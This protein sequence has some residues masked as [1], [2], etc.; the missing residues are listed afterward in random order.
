MR[1]AGPTGAARAWCEDVARRPCPVGAR[2]PLPAR[3]GG[4]IAAI[5]L[6]VALPIQAHD[7]QLRWRTL[8]SAHIEVHHPAHL[9]VFARKVLETAEDA[10]AALVPLFGYQPPVPLQ[11]TVDD[12]VDGSNGFAG[13]FPYDHILIRAYPPAAGDDLADPGD[14]VR[15]LVFHEITHILHVGDATGLP[16]LVNTV[17]GRTHLP[18]QYL[19]RFFV[20]G[21]ATY[22][23]TR[24]VGA[25]AS[26]QRLAAA[27]GAGTRHLDADV[28][29]SGAGAGRDLA[30]VRGGR[31]DGAIFMGRLRAA[32][33][34]GTFPSVSQLIG[35]PLDWPRG[36]G[37]YLY[38]SWLLDFQARRYGHDRL[39]RFISGYGG[40]LVPYG[41]NNLTRSVYGKSAIALWREAT[42]ALDVRVRRERRLRAAGLVPPVSGDG[43]ARAHAALS[44]GAAGRCGPL[45]GPGLRLSRDGEGRGRVRMAPGGRHVVLSRSP[46]DDI[47]RIER[48]ALADG[49][50]E[51]LHRCELDCDDALIT[52]D[53]GWLLWVATRPYRRQYQFRDV[54]ARRLQ[55]G[56]GAVGPVLR[57]T[58]GLRAREISVDPAGR[59]LWAV[60]VR[61]GLTAI[62]RLPLAPALT[63]AAA[64]RAIPAVAEVLRAQRHADVL[65]TP[66]A[67]RDGRLFFTQGRGVTRELRAAPL[68][69][70]GRLSAP[71]R[72]LPW[73]PAARVG[74]AAEVTGVAARTALV[75]WLDE[76]QVIERDQGVSLGAVV[77]LGSFRD[78]AELPLSATAVAADPARD[79]RWQLRSWSPTSVV[80]AAFASGSTRAVA[81]QTEHHGLDLYRLDPAPVERRLEPQPLQWRPASAPPPF[82]PYA[83]GIAAQQQRDYRAWP[84]LYPQAWSPIAEIVAT[85]APPTAEDVTLGLSLDGRDAVGLYAWELLAQSDLALTHPRLFLSTTWT[86]WEPTLS[87]AAAWVHDDLYARRGFR[88]L[89]LRNRTASGRLG[90]AW[91]L[92]LGRDALGFDLGLRLVSR[93]ARD[94]L[95]LWRLR[96]GAPVPYGPVPVDPLQGYEGEA[97]AGVSW[98]RSERYPQSVVTERR[99]TY[100]L[101]GTWARH[102]TERDRELVRI[103]LHGD[104]A[105]PLGGHR[106]LSWRARLGW[107]PA[108]HPG[109][110]PYR[111]VGLPPLDIEALLLGG[112]GGDFGVVRGVTDP[113]RA[114]REVA[115]RALA[116]SSLGL[117]LPLPP[118][119]RGLDLLPFFL[120]RTWA[121]VFAD[122]AVILA[123]DETRL[124]EATTGPGAVLSAGAEVAVDLE[125]AYIS[126]GALKLGWAR[127][128]GDIDSSQWYIRLGL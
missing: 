94:D 66:V 60:A 39:K 67:T 30:A 122:G 95:A 62:V 3:I 73:M 65:A 107:S 44:V 93:A 79:P 75:T 104:H 127:A 37:W 11:I 76:L 4:L 10:W 91:A 48:V 111:L 108:Y 36:R 70:R 40:R 27:D 126:Q 87:L 121:S 32:S 12:Y 74:L 16:A 52:P 57:L 99:R 51:V 110:P 8:S 49:A 115:G 109:S 77:Q 128:F 43:V 55:P 9:E 38:G 31:V 64:G 112:A 17:L 29:G 116:W 106:V 13:S 22:V 86:R 7:G 2:A 26:V 78:A 1:V 103:D 97:S 56:A 114:G 24:H 53:G 119:G 28:G 125:A 58:E 35:Q 102:L 88:V 92:P 46:G 81:L 72:P 82:L 33:L 89:R 101:Y 25:D 6:L 71:H 50:V 84:T 41:I 5:C 100:R 54:F 124:R 63:A 80:S 15:A 98:S 69:A 20:E 68:D 59:A 118:I 14:W 117:H 47:A 113:V 45:P 96:A 21:L 23:E 90:V 42:D 34:A 123:G 83:P 85:G 18:N 61:D 105:W 120:G 19:P